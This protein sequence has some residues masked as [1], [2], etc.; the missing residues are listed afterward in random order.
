MCLAKAYL[1]GVDTR[2]LVLEDVALLR[3]DG[4]TL[5]LQTLFGRE[6]LL[7]GR[8]REVNFQDST[9]VIEQLEHGT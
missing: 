4:D 7:E 3:V 9:I 6:K 2:K 8:M 1:S 5:T